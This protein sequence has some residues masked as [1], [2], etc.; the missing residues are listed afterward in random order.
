MDVNEVGKV[1]LTD[2]PPIHILYVDLHALT[3]FAKYELPDRPIFVASVADATDAVFRDT[4][5]HANSHRH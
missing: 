2:A 3:H 1:C 4:A 5:K